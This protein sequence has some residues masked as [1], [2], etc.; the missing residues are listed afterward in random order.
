MHSSVY[1]GFLVWFILYSIFERCNS[2]DVIFGSFEIIVF[3]RV[4]YWWSWRTTSSRAESIFGMFEYASRRNDWKHF[5]LVD[6]DV[7]CARIRLQI[8]YNILSTACRSCIKYNFVAILVTK[9]ALLMDCRYFFQ[10][11]K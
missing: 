3:E 9:N 2:I 7:I 10:T 5:L 1:R 4:Y 11:L 8:A 6:D